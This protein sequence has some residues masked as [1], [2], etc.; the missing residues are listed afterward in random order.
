MNK[1]EG[2][3]VFGWSAPE[4]TMTGGVNPPNE[5]IHAVEKLGWLVMF[6]MNPYNDPT[7]AARKL[8]VRRAGWAAVGA[9]PADDDAWKKMIQFEKKDAVDEPWGFKV[10]QEPQRRYDIDDAIRIPYQTEEFVIDPQ[11]GQQVVQKRFVEYLLIGVSKTQVAATSTVTWDAN[12]TP[13]PATIPMPT[14]A[15][16]SLGAMILSLAADNIGNLRQQADWSKVAADGLAVDSSNRRRWEFRCSGRKIDSAL[17]IPFVKG[18]KLW[19][20][21]VGYEGGGAY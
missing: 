8:R 14:T 19:Y 6:K 21:F 18:G 7:G 12:P 1:S 20:L 5:P 10:P 9:N 13:P 16:A 3:E 15:I 2:F 4:W 11:S 17:R